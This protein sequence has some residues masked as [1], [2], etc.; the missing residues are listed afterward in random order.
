MVKADM[1]IVVFSVSLLLLLFLFSFSI[2]FLFYFIL[3]FLT[4]I[5]WVGFCALGVCREAAS[6]GLAVIDVRR[7]RD[8]VSQHYA[9]RVAGRGGGGQVQICPHTASPA[10]PPTEQGA[11]APGPTNPTGHTNPQ[12]AR[13][14]SPDPQERQSPAHTPHHPTSTGTTKYCAKNIRTPATPR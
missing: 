8:Y 6:L 4:F 9:A 1:I 11:Q 14:G 7:M 2:C 5:S 10:G 3:L 12:K 13:Q